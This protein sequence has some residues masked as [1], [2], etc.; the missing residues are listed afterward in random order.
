MTETGQRIEARGA[1]PVP[2]RSAGRMQFQ[3][4]ELAVRGLSAIVLAVIT[5]LIT[6]SGPVPFAGL[7]ICI[8]GVLLWEWGRITGRTHL[9]AGAG[10]G[11]IATLAAVALILAGWDWAALGVMGAGILA[12]LITAREGNANLEAIGVAYAG[13]PA[14]ALTWMRAAPSG[15]DVVL[16]VFLIV[17]ATDIGAYISG[18]AI[19]GPKL[20]PQISPN[21]TWSGLVGGVSCAALAAW[22][23]ARSVGSPIPGGVALIALALGVLSQLGDLAESGL[24]RAYGVKDASGLIPGHGGFMDRVDGLIFAAVGAAIYAVI[25]GHGSPGRALLGL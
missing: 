23:F 2:N 5:L 12:T 25:A 10:P 22:L 24:K 21:K 11:A 13:L 1:D 14:I 15:W 6:W 20:C 18:R 3:A 19:G 4:R 17:W 8:T 9:M 16:L 7:A